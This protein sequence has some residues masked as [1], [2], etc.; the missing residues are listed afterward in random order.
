[1][2]NPASRAIAWA[3]R[4]PVPVAAGVGSVA[5]LA[6]YSRRRADQAAAA[7]AAAPPASSIA[8][9]SAGLTPGDVS[10]LIGQGAGLATGAFALGQAPT[11][12]ALDLAGTGLGV[13]GSA[14]GT[15]AG[16]QAAMGATLGGAFGDLV[17]AVA[18]IF[19]RAEPAPTYA[20]A[21]TAPAPAPA[22]T[23]A[24]TP[25][26]PTAARIT[27]T[28]RTFLR[29]E[30]AVRAG[31]IDGGLGS[32]SAGFTPRRMTF[33]APSWAPVSRYVCSLGVAWRTASGGY[34][35]VHYLSWTTGWTGSSLWSVRKRYRVTER[36]SDG[37]TTTR[38]IT[39]PIGKTGS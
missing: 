24:P 21:P 25:A 10:G 20:P 12:A 1:M 17:G 5:F 26:A 34:T 3:R 31:T 36:W 38:E 18:P 4:N 33:A 15:L 16:S 35:G 22:P 14:V 11:M 39:E 8:A 7:A 29:Y 27:S 30:V 13:L 19:E 2:A 37:R 23:P 28:S 9:G 6:S 32:C